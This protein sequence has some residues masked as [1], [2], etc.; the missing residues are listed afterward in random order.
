MNP[1]SIFI[2]HSSSDKDLVHNTI[3]I[4]GA[5]GIS[6]DEYVFESGEKTEDEINLA[7]DNAAIFCL[8]ISKSSM[9]KDWVLK[10]ISRYKEN[11]YRRKNIKFLPLIIDE[12]ID[13]DYEKIPI[14]ITEE[15]NLREK[16]LNPV[17]LARKLEEELNKLRW[18]LFPKIR[19]RELLFA[20]RDH[21]MARLRE[22]FS[23]ANYR[24]RRALIV[25]GIPD[26]I[27]R[28]RFLVEF[29]NTMESNRKA[30]YQP[31]SIAIDR[32]D[33][34]EDF[35]MRINSLT[36]SY[37]NE[38]LIEKLS[39][40]SR[41]EKIEL[42]NSILMEL[43]TH[44]ENLLIRDNGA[45]VM[46]NGDISDWF[47]E[48]IETSNIKKTFFYIASKYRFLFESEIPQI[49]SFPLSPLSTKNAKVLFNELAWKE[50]L[51]LSPEDTQFFLDKTANMPQLIFNCVKQITD[52]G[53]DFAKNFQ[54]NYEYKGEELVKSLID[55]FKDKPDYIQILLLLSEVEFL[56]YNQIKKICQDTIPNTDE[57][58]MD[59][60]SLSIYEHFG[61]NGEF[62][63]MNSIISD[64]L[65]RS[66]YQLDSEIWSN[67]QN[68]VNEIIEDQDFETADLGI[69]SKK[70][71]KEIKGDIRNINRNH[72]IPSI[73]LRI[74]RDEYRIHR[75]K[76]YENV[77]SICNV[78]LEHKNHYFDDIIGRINYY[79]CASYAQLGS[80]DLF[81][82]WN[83][84]KSSDK[85]FL[86][87][88][89]YRK[90]REY[91]KAEQ[92]F[93][94][95]LDENPNNVRIKNEL[96]I[97]LQRQRKYSE[98]QELASIAYHTHPTNPFYIVTYFKSLVRNA[99]IEEKNLFDL[100]NQL[101][102]SW[103]INKIAISKMLEA[104]FQYFRRKD[105]YSALSLYTEALQE[106]RY[107]P[108]FISATEICE[109]SG[110]HNEIVKL[111]DQFGFN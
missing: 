110:H 18:S 87:G 13:H 97:S 24:N 78:V 36:L 40:L 22:K 8:L 3:E 20:G 60:Y 44:K 99:T 21:D 15:Y 70:I 68:K 55:E 109:L 50:G 41:A 49:L 4:L 61:S 26:G 64:L 75:K 1:I 106:S 103:D 69:L 2:S 28:R 23:D 98:A 10:E 101:K 82:N 108:V 43:Y 104:E 45:I 6:V 59:L 66:R 42:A 25:S 92:K 76:A 89:Y 79:L 85:K 74:I 107:Y 84:L 53:I 105:F 72:I 57:I 91:I 71:E 102:A 33:S 16:F 17:F 93:R 48:I 34:I 54:R 37:G 73:A 90:K 30:S 56:T 39:I 95:A 94:D 51:D 67:I 14:W 80:D 35:I 12:S 77:I 58:L 81:L 27:G 9:G 83:D 88:I 11:I 32:D 47:E 5:N 52:N 46:S 86:N 7:I 111:G 100:I 38:S 29:I 31:V 63:R 65:K 19:E 62:I 96:A